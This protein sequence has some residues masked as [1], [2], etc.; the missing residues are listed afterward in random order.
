MKVE[1]YQ[2]GDTVAH[3]VAADMCS[4]LFLQVIAVISG[5]KKLGW[6]FLQRV[7]LPTLTRLLPS[8]KIKHKNETR[9]SRI[10][11]ISQQDELEDLSVFETSLRATIRTQTCTLFI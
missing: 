6:A 3:P 1:K 2:R 11:E 8:G 9:A 10:A 5:T 4:I 7:S